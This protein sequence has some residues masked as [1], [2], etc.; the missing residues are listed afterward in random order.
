MGSKIFSEHLDLIAALTIHGSVEVTRKRG[1]MWI[2]SF[3]DMPKESYQL[4]R[5]INVLMISFP[6]FF[7]LFCPEGA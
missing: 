2:L 1:M 4:S 5:D 6:R 3:N 7:V